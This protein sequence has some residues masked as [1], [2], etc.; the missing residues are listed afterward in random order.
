MHLSRA[1]W[2]GL[3]LLSVAVVG[4]GLLAWWPAA[5]HATPVVAAIGPVSRAAPF[6]RSMQDTLPDG[7]LQAIQ[8]GLAASTSGGLAYGELKRLFDY[9]LSAVGEQ[10]IETITLQIRGELDRRLPPAQA[11]KAQRLLGLYIEFKRELVRVESQPQLVGNSLQAIRGRFTAMQ[12]IR[13]RYF[14]AEESEGMFGF[15]DSYDMD[16]IAR[17]EVSQ[18]PALTAEQKKQ[19]LAALDA[20]LP[21][22]LRKEREASSVVVRV[23]QQAQELRAKGGSDDDVYRMRA[24]ELDPQAA[25]RLADVDREEAI[26][27]GR[28]TRYLEERSKLLQSQA[29]ASASEREASLAQ[30]QQSA[31]S[32]A[33]R[34]RLKA[35]E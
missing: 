11:Q 1:T 12:D 32:E 13:A 33:E 15:D 7:D 21:E 29:N 34:P 25:A 18:N 35:Y 6:V 9:Y 30:L 22:Q 23:E 2:V 24:K 5:E 27:K 19:Q 8:K 4:A 17:L 16:A 26:W 31:F 10:S 3:G 28:I 20:A 14:S